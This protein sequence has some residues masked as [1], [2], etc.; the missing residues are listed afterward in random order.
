MLLEL[1]P[2]PPVLVE[3]IIRILL[4]R[5]VL[6]RLRQVAPYLRFLRLL[7]HFLRLHLRLLRLAQFLLVVQVFSVQYAKQTMFHR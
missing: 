5:L 4:A 3:V 7:V 2:I 6:Q 1:R